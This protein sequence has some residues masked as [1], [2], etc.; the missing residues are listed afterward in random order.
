MSK[1]NITMIKQKIVAIHVFDL[2]ST[3]F[4][5]IIDFTYPNIIS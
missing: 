1:Y 4:F 5:F 3:T 2:V